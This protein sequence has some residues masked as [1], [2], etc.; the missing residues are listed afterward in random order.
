M[1]VTEEF[2]FQ[3]IKSKFIANGW[4]TNDEDGSEL[5]GLS[6]GGFAVAYNG[7]NL[8]GLPLVT[9][10][11]ANFNQVSAF[12]VPYTGSAPNMVGHPEIIELANGNVAVIWDEG[13]AGNGDDEVRAS[14]INPATGAIEVSEFQVSSFASDTEPQASAL[15]NGNWVVVMSNSNNLSYLQ[16][17]DS[18]GAKVGGQITIDT[19]TN[20]ST[21][22]VIT[23]LNG[24]GFVVSFTEAGEIHAKIY[25]DD[26]TVRTVEFTIATPGL[27]DSYGQPAL[28]ATLNGGFVVVHRYDGNGALSVDEIELSYF[29]S[30]GTLVT[31]PIVVASTQFSAS[32]NPDVTVLSNGFVVVSW[33]DSSN[34]NDIMA[35]VYD[36]SGNAVSLNGST[37][38]ILIEGGALSQSDASISSFFSGVFGVTWTD[39]ITDGD[40]DSIGGE[41]FEVFREVTGD[42]AANT[43]EGSAIRDVLF[44]AGGDD[45]FEFEGDWV[46]SND[47]IDGGGASIDTLAA[48]DGGAFVR[49]F[50]AATILSIDRMTF[51][52]FGSQDKTMIFSSHQLGGVGI[53]N[54]LAVFGSANTNDVIQINID[55]GSADL[56]GWTFGDWT[57]NP[58]GP[59]QDVIN[60][61]GAATNDIII[62]S[63]EYDLIQGNGGNDVLV[64]GGGQDLV[65]GGAGDDTLI[66]SAADI[67]V[68]N[69]IING[70]ADTDT[71]QTFGAGAAAY[72]FRG[73]D[74]VSIER[75][76]FANS[77]AGTSIAKFNADQI[78][79][80]NFTFITYIS[81][82][83][84]ITGI[85]TFGFNEIIE[86]YMGAASSLD[87]SGWTFANW[88]NQLEG[89]DI[90]GDGDAETITGSSQADSIDADSGNDIING[91][92]G[93][94]TIRGATGMDTIDG[95]AGNDRIVVL[96]GDESGNEIVNGGADT[97][98][99]AL[100]TLSGSYIYDFTSWT[101][102]SIEQI[103]FSSD[104][105]GVD[106]VID[107][108]AS[109]IGAGLSSTA[110]ISAS[111]ID[112]AADQI[113]IAM[114]TS[115]TLDLSGWT[116]TNWGGANGD[117]KIFVTGDADAET[118]TGTSQIDVLNGQ[119]GIDV[120]N[121]GGGNDVITG[122]TGA[123]T[124]NGGD[125]NDTF[126]FVDGDISVGN[127]TINGGSG[128]D[129]ILVNNTTGNHIFDFRGS[130]LTSIEE[131]EF[132]ATVTGFNT[133]HFNASQIGAGVSSSL[134]V[135]GNNGVDFD[136]DVSITMGSVTTLDLSGWTF[137]SFGGQID[138]INFFGDN[139]AENMIGSSRDDDF[140][141]EGG[142][143]I[144]IG[145]AGDD[146]FDGGAGDDSAN[147]GA[148]DDT[149]H[150]NYDDGA[151]TNETV[152]GGADTDNIVFHGNG[153]SAI[154]V[155]GSTF[156]SIEEIKMFAQASGQ[157]T[158]RFDAAHLAAPAFQAP[159]SYSPITPQVTAI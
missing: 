79:T 108:Q 35:R 159:Q 45:T 155:R 120:L 149:F 63:S 7:S 118:I 37:N 4:T 1:A 24:G 116:F 156:T 98:T 75:F 30:N 104:G 32:S 57:Y 76:T 150:M 8:N 62:G 60:I 129:R 73:S 102:T 25:E 29:S 152:D 26:G 11:D 22:P 61:F 43:I 91:G 110:A 134:H 19:A 101:I 132:S 18:T 64:G 14:I 138:E 23:T 36:A 12:T 40:G 21:E 20:D 78:G 34:G 137:T 86:I 56:S 5:I 50:S 72:D 74:I 99:L 144:M 33:E 122:G 16:I 139:D 38:A 135:I 128:T 117:D 142:N 88:G 147:G 100:A 55:N 145:N 103:E 71:I 119:G 140:F 46:Q 27:I 106:K 124:V 148:G 84:L 127:E 151:L 70:G 158:V 141:G 153:T 51:E 9:F 111:G 85:D 121:G 59:H 66:F 80:D 157:F 146:T 48:I 112:I 3:T 53:S 123:D 105:A 96:N 87:I 97:D 131:V 130:T 13:S 67:S 31:G 58:V 83:A 125:D 93:N 44:G 47:Y 6:N 126:V 154:D 89:I 17:M 82:T 69:E 114:G 95:G 77:V 90:L 92:G 2:K 81:S 68:G 109:Q 54:S 28:A 39:E 52:A 113:R 42:A 115:S 94:D 65:H 136:D 15:S 41:V 133:I 143:D 107:I 49:D 10:Y